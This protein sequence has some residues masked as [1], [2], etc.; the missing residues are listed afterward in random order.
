MR[1]LVSLVF[2]PIEREWSTVDRA[3]LPFITGRII[4]SDVVIR[5]E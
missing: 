2:D 1:R 5:D 4:A 3:V